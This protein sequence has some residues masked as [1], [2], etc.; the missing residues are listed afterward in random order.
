ML[1]YFIMS[2]YS[3]FKFKVEPP[4]VVFQEVPDHISLAF[5][6]GGCPLKCRGCHSSHTWNKHYGFEL[7]DCKLKQ[8]LEQY[9]GLVSCVVFFGGEWL[10]EQ[11]IDKLNLAKQ[12]GFKTCLYT[13][14]QNVSN[15]ILQQLD[16]LKTGPWIQELG[17]LESPH[18]NQ[19]FI[20]VASSELLNFKFHH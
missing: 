16:Y 1:F 7:T 4:Q 17:G 15:A 13:G 5:V 18:T 20:E 6:V 2:I 9:M 8:Y 3:V 10:P 12:M 19:R 11:L 14:N